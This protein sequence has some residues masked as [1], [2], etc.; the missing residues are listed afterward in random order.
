MNDESSPSGNPEINSNNATLTPEPNPRIKALQQRLEDRK[1]NPLTSDTQTTRQKRQQQRESDREEERRLVDE[2]SADVAQSTDDPKETIAKV[3]R[4]IVLSRLGIA[5]LVRES[6]AGSIHATTDRGFG[7]APQVVELD[8]GKGL[9]VT[10]DLSNLSDVALGFLAAL[11]SAKAVAAKVAATVDVDAEHVAPRQI[12]P[13]QAK[14]DQ[15]R[16]LPRQ[17]FF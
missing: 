10:M 4:K 5:S 12:G 15:P 3:C 13:N 17:T 2:I 7:K 1:N 16:K 11:S 14:V 6:L 9:Q 8:H